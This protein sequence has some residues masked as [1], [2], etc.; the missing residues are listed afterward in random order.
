[1][2]GKNPTT[3][4]KTNMV[5]ELAKSKDEPDIELARPEDELLESAEEKELEKQRRAITKAFTT[6]MV[7]LMLCAC[8]Y[9]GALA[10]VKSHYNFFRGSGRS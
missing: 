7:A 5:I 3:H 10:F 6:K 2:D 4:H 8:L 1:M 9:F